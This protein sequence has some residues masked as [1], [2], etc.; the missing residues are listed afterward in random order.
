VQEPEQAEPGQE[1]ERSLACFEQ[2][3]GAQNGRIGVPNRGQTRIFLLN[4]ARR[5]R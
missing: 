1:D 5:T 3:D 2:G 4:G